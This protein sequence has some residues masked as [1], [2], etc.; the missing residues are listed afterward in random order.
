M[1]SNTTAAN[2]TANGMAQMSSFFSSFSEKMKPLGAQA[3]KGFSQ[4]TQVGL[5]S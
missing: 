3:A 5:L 4:A 2:A 1:A